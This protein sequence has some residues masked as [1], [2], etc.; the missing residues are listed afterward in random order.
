MTDITET[1]ARWR[2]FPHL[3]TD[4]EVTLIDTGDLRALLDAAEAG[5]RARDAALEEAAVMAESYIVKP[6]AGWTLPTAIRSLR[7]PG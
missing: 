6:G 7:R 1:I 2:R 4:S 5:A 3:L